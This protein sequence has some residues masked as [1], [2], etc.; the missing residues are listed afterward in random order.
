MRTYKIRKEKEMKRK[1]EIK[2][3]LS[4]EIKT[5]LTNLPNLN[6]G[7][8]ERVAAVND[9][10]NLYKLRIEEAKLELDSEERYNKRI[11]EF[12]A[13]EEESKLKERQFKEQ[14]KERRLKI[15]V[16]VAGIVLPLGVYCYQ[17]FK[18][19]KFEETGTV[20]SKFFGNLLNRFK[21]TK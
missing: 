18:G 4:E 11:D 17:F 21:P 5:E 9:L 19:L 3:L 16:E 12:D 20:T 15:G 13:R 8:K 10:T 6:Y 1:D 2:D 14:V 7:S